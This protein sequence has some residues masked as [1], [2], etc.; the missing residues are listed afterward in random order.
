M[1]E[2]E[3]MA[4]FLADPANHGGA[5]TERFDTHTA[6]VVVAG[7]HA[8]E[9]RRPVDYGWL[10]YGT[11]ARRRN[12]GEHEIEVNSTA[13]PGLYLGLAGI[14]PE[15]DGWRLTGLVRTFRRRSS[16]WC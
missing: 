12:C 7:E 3:S 16:R 6:T 14:V 8:W 15:R 5:E 9:L 10:D 4:A 2:W 1:D 13:A 11:R